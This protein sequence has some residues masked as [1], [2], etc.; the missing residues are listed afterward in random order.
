MRKLAWLPRRLHVREELELGIELL[1]IYLR[2]DL[3]V[4]KRENP[5][6]DVCFIL[7]LKK[8]SEI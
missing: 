8:C 1:L 3:A 7:T 4:Q 5:K 2:L 6:I